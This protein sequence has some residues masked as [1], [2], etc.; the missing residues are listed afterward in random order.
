MARHGNEQGQCGRKGSTK[1][2]GEMQKSQFFMFGFPHQVCLQVCGTR[3]EVCGRNK[4][5]SRD[6]K[7]FL[8]KG[9]QQ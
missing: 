6:V 2:A 8:L 3:D 4:E 9:V 5:R 1:D 7:A